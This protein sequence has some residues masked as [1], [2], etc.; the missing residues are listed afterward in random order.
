MTKSNTVVGN[1]STLLYTVADVKQ[2][3]GANARYTLKNIVQS[4]QAFTI[5]QFISMHFSYTSCCVT[6]SG[7]RNKI[8][9]LYNA[10]DFIISGATEY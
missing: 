5:C 10:G 3:S 4:G 2:K 8:V 7:N 9:T 6:V 1:S